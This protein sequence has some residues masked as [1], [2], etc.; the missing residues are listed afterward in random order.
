MVYVNE[1]LTHNVHPGKGHTK[2]SVHRS[3]QLT[4]VNGTMI[5]IV[6]LLRRSDAA[7]FGQ[8]VSSKVNT[9]CRTL[10]QNVLCLLFYS[11]GLGRYTFLQIQ[12][13]MRHIL[14]LF[15][16]I[17]CYIYL[18]IELIYKIATHSYTRGKARQIY[19]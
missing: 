4:G 3:L 17:I 9:W 19:L 16:I 14:S 11:G 6:V 18:Y 2:A 7:G 5:V 12:Y 8:F 1:L 10:Y 15:H 13:I